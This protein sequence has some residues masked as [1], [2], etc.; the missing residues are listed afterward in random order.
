MAD[1]HHHTANGDYW[2]F[3]VKASVFPPCSAG[4]RL[5]IFAIMRVFST[6]IPDDD[7]RN[8]VIMTMMIACFEK[9]GS[10]DGEDIGYA[11]TS[12]DK[13]WKLELS[14]YQDDE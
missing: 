3:L 2:N 9:D 10:V 13:S 5:F 11:A 4:S 12:D 14:L 8:A 1:G 7:D 6:L